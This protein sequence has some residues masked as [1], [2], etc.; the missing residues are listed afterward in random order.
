MKTPHL[1]KPI[2][3]WLFTCAGFVFAMIII[4][5]ITRLT[6]SGLSMVEWR[7][8]IGT[9]PPMNEAEWQRVF[10]LYQ[11]T[12]EFQKKNFWMEIDDFKTIFFW[13]WFH[14]FWG[15]LIGLVYALPLA[16]FWL[17]DMIPAGYKGKLL[18]LLALGGAQ[19]V[20]GWYMVESGLID[21]P[22][23][24][25]FRLA[26]HLSLAF[27]ILCILTWLGLKMAG[28]AQQ[29]STFCLRRHGWSAFAIVGIT[30]LWG[31]FVAGLDAGLVY[32]EY[33]LMGGSFMPPEMWH[34]TPAIANIFEN[35]AAVQFTH[36]WIAIIAAVFVLSFSW[37]A[38]KAG[39]KLARFHALGGMVLLQVGLGIV[40]LL[41]NVH[42]H[43]AV[44][45]QAGAAILLVFMTASLHSLHS[46]RKS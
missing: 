28:S 34:L 3:T 43:V 6:E 46:S 13:E 19:A 14:R 44:T 18:G 45:H 40:T 36:R 35:P 16:F 10:A 22:A 41:T 4:G 32:N 38:I 11:E 27:I 29:K 8:L 21:N 2:A 5:A 31:A 30:V 12:P 25:H 42:L 1:S 20:M 23:V 33:P 9:L 24:S 15:R 7:P 26:A 39:H 17:R 37:R